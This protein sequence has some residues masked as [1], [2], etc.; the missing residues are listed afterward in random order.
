MTVAEP[1]A[2]MEG[3]AKP[4]VSKMLLK[5]EELVERF[6]YDLALKFCERILSVEPRHV[7]A[8]QMKAT[9]LID[10]GDA[11]AARNVLLSATEAE[12]DCGAE[13]YIALAQ[14]SEGEEALEYFQRA[15]KILQTGEQDEETLHT[16]ASLYCSMAEL[17]LT[18]LC[19]AEDAETRCE[20]FVQAALDASPQNYE[21]LQTMCSMRLS[22]NREEEAAEVLSQSITKWSSIPYEDSEYPSFEFR[23]TCSR[24]LVELGSYDLAQYILE[25][26]SQEDD[27]IIEVWYLLAL[28]L[29]TQGSLSPAHEALLNAE[30]M[31]EG[32]IPELVDAISELREAIGTPETLGDATMED[33]DNNTEEVMDTCTE[34]SD[35]P[36]EE[37]Q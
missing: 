36:A 1:E 12:P 18:D 19:L 6:E 28:S 32:V 3:S 26:L 20:E 15:V 24:L 14:L 7:D 31:M 10:M 29:Y 17:F 23:L 9:I 33:D 21:A 13:K 22:Q 5:C 4:D 11:E 27:E 8:L 2:S 34:D 35:D 37:D 25:A 30:K 16:L